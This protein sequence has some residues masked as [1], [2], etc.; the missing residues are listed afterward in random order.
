MHL[1]DAFLAATRDAAES[2]ILPD[3][4]NNFLATSGSFSVE[5]DSST[6]VSS[7]RSLAETI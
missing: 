3:A 4:S 5:V 1:F 2:T 7:S 6:K